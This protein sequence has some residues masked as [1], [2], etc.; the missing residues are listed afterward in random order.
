VDTRTKI[1]TVEEA[2]Q[3]AA[4][5]ATPVSG[6]FDPLLAA[7]AVRLSTLKVEGAP[8]LILIRD[9]DH[10]IL[11]ARARMEL[12]AALACV[13]FVAALPPGFTAGIELEAQHAR[14]FDD[15]VDRVHA[16]Q[17]AAL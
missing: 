15:L 14:I 13:D 10:P 3:L 7:H 17:R 9:P 6:F 5:G 4:S 8:L 2:L 12:V 16:R 11:P 1:V